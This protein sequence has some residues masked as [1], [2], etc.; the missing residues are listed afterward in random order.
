MRR[1]VVAVAGVLL[2]FVGLA[3]PAHAATNVT[4]TAWTWNVAGWTIHRGSTTDG[5][6]P[7]LT[8]SVQNRGAQLVA[9]NELCQ[10]Q[11]SAIQASLKAA[12]W[13]S[14]PTNFSRFEAHSS[15]ACGGQP[16]GLAIFSKY[17]LGAAN[18][19]T[20]SS[21]GDDEARKLLC[22]PLEARPH[23]RFCTTHITTSNLVINGQKINETQLNEVRSRLEGFNTAGDTVIIAGDFNAQPNYGRLNN[24]YSSTLNTSYNSSNTGAYREL[25]DTDTRCTGYG[26]ETTAIGT[27]G[28]GLCGQEPKVDL[29]FVRAN[30]ISGSYSA[31][32]LAIPTCGSSPCSDHRVLYGSVQVSVN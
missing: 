2:M 30:R 1:F 23:L 32:S 18:R 25:D 6:V 24:W 14:D 26:E 12:G 27:S 9:V 3:L 4:Y 28:E 5:L 8:S 15:T 16:F 20:L 7:A 19:Y 10:G 21:D 17:P 11:Y 22:A 13:P 31:D 29:I